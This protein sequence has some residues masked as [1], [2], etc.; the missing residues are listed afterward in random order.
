MRY[1]YMLVEIDI[2]PSNFK[3]IEFTNI[4]PPTLQEPITHNKATYPP[5][6][7]YDGVDE[8]EFDKI[9]ED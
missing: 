3:T 2:M 5:F 9:N 4:P 7:R 8:N 6:D 1:A